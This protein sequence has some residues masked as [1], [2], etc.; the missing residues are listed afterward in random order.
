MLTVRVESKKEFGAKVCGEWEGVISARQ[1]RRVL[2]ALDAFAHEA[3]LQGEALALRL[4]SNDERWLAVGGPMLGCELQSQAD[5][6]IATVRFAA[7]SWRT[8]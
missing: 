8:W 6:H 4:K 3:S 2:Q 1:E 7:D 5:N